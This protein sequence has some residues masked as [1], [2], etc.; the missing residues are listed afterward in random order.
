MHLDQ[1]PSGHDKR[2]KQF[3]ILSL[4]FPHDQGLTC[5]ICRCSGSTLNIH[6]REELKQVCWF[7]YLYYGT[8][9]FEHE[10]YQ[11][12]VRPTSTFSFNET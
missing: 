6:L 4:I 10:A 7:S 12:S 9:L 2:P 1:Y 5:V 3:F 8:K 11:P